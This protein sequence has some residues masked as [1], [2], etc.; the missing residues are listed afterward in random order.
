[1][2]ILYVVVTNA[3]NVVIGKDVYSGDGVDALL[4]SKQ[5]SYSSLTFTSTDI[6]TFNSTVFVGPNYAF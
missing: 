3:S 6:N 1:M 2:A 5:A 4:A